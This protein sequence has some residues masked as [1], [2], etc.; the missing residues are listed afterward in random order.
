MTATSVVIAARDAG[1]TVQRA[2]ASALAQDPAEVIVV[3]D[4][5]SDATADLA[6]ATSS[7]VRVVRPL[8]HRTL[9]FARQA[10]IDAVRTELAM[11]LDADDEFLPGRSVAMTRALVDSGA[12]MAFDGVEVV[13]GAT[14]RRTAVVP[15][16]EFL[17]QPPFL[18]RL[19]ERNYLP[20]IGAFAFRTEAIRRVGYDPGLHGSEDVDIVLRAVA[21][22]CGAALLDSVGYRVHAYPGSLSRQLVNQRS[23]YA[24]L[25]RKHD[26]AAVRRLL[27]RSGASPIVLAW[28]LVSFAIHREDHEAALAFLNEVD[29]HAADPA[30]IVEPHGPTPIMEGWRRGFQRGTLLLLLGRPA[31]ALTHLEAAESG[32]PTAEGANN[33]GVALFRLGE[34]A[35][36]SRCFECAI[37]RYPGYLDARLN[38]TAAIPERITSQPLRRQP[39]RDDYPAPHA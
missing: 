29:S 22:G 12:D 37:A 5:S 11:W 1:G 13:D 27:E 39:Y 20:G 16:P 10:G 24:T 18:A 34:K 6:T 25:L 19:F 36:G 31:E 14:G 32:H 3:D 35:S 28:A 30:T 9:G 26:P 7:R 17:R 15:V 23:M 33:L 8:E 21:A 4:W 38:S 2:V